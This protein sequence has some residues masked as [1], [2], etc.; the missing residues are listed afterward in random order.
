MA[1][2]KRY[3]RLQKVMVSDRRPNSPFQLSNLRFHVL[4]SGKILSSLIR[5]VGDAL[6]YTQYYKQEDPIV[7]LEVD[8]NRDSEHKF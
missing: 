5:L 2:L 3:G 7:R 6:L 1:H 4:V 8:L